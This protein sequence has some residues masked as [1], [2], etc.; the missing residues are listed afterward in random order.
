[1][2][3]CL[4][5]SGPGNS[6]F[7]QSL[8]DGLRQDSLASFRQ[9]H[10]R[11]STDAQSL[12]ETVS[13]GPVDEFY[14]TVV[15]QAQLLCQ[16]T[17]G[18]L[19]ILGQS[20]YYQQELILLGLD[21]GPKGGLIAE[22]EVA[23]YVIT[24]L[25][26]RPIIGVAQGFLPRTLPRRHDR[27][28][29]NVPRLLPAGESALLGGFGLVAYCIV[30]TRYSPTRNMLLLMF[31]RELVL[32]IILA[33]ASIPFFLFTRSMAAR[34]RQLSIEVATTWYRRGEQQLKS[35]DLVE[36]IRSFRKAAT[37]DHG[38]SQYVM[39]LATSL[40]AADH[41]EEA[42]QTLMQ[43]RASSPESGQI[44][45]QLAKLAERN[46]AKAEAV[47]YYHNALYGLWPPAEMVPQRRSI[48]ADLA[49][50][51]LD[52]GDRG[53]ALSELL[54]LSADIPDTAPAHSDVGRL[55]LEAGDWQRA[56]EQ[57]LLALRMDPKNVL[58]LEG[59]GRASFN[60]GDYIKARR[61]LDSAI[62]SERNTPAAEEL[63]EITRL[64]LS[65]DPLAPLLSSEERINRLQKGLEFASAV[66]QS[67]GAERIGDESTQTL[68]NLLTEL[69]Q[70]T[71]TR[72]RPADLKRDAEGFSSGMNLIY[73]IESTAG[74]LCHEASPTGKALLLIAQKHGDVEQ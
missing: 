50:Y 37:N 29:Y 41:I 55:F 66:L 27:R 22:L 6:Q 60:A 65:L 54:V 44:N 72:Y 73:R 57:F 19:D 15:A 45:L 31:H 7:A 16:Y 30:V 25:R 39:A 17:D 64:V 35:R 62:A 3:K 61:Y 47:R 2:L 43:L 69:N 59:A 58:A 46:G 38:N 63:L 24:K 14:D 71:Q 20:S 10:K 23:A 26:Q 70:D 11:S 51:L 8:F 52:S 36:A 13:L 49:R 67:C 33:V 21:T 32:L 74:R 1:M 42:R 12:Y 5:K 48:R 56:L 18:R 28:N 9:T 34:N 53:Q 68:Q 40:A 4:C